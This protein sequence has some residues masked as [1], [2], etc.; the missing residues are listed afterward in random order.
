VSD[1]ASFAI[2]A[3]IQNRRDRGVSSLAVD[4][5]SIDIIGD[6][7]R[8]LRNLISDIMDIRYISAI[9]TSQRRNDYIVGLNYACLP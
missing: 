8:Q 5:I 7:N 4:S 6:L 9:A 2:L 1:S 3:C